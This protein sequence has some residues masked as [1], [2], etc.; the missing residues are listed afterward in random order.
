MRRQSKL[1]CRW[2]TEMRKTGVF[3]AGERVGVA[4]SGG[5]DSILLLDF[6]GQFASKV[7]LRV[8]VVHFNHLLRGEESNQDESF[9]SALAAR[10]KLEFIRAEGDVGRVARQTRR[11]LEATARELRYR[12]FF[13]L[14]RQGRLDRIAT[15][16]TAN[17]QAETV[18]LRLMRGAGARGLGGIHPVLDGVIVR[19]FLGITRQEVEAEIRS[20]RLEFRTDT[21]NLD[22]RFVRNRIRQKLLP[23]LET[24]FNAAIVPHLKQLADHMRSDEDLLEQQAREQARPWRIR[25][26]QEEKIPLRALRELPRALQVR[27]L[28]QMAASALSGQASLSSVQFE[29]ILHFVVT[30]VSGK[31]LLLA[32]GLEVRRDFD[33]LALRH[34]P[35]EGCAAPYCYAVPLPGEVAVPALGLKFRFEVAENPKTKG[36]DK[37]YNNNEG[38]IRLDLGKFQGSL[39][40]RN[41]REGDRFQ[42]VGHRKSCKLKELFRER[43]IPVAHRKL[44]PVIEGG[45]EIVW[46]RSFPSSLAAV[47]TST[48]SQFLTIIE[49]PLQLPGSG[50]PL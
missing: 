29:S 1:Y 4:V 21:S 24:E 38:L 17:D 7:G 50:I 30:A 3:R 44:W 2:D 26:G 19:P 8:S 32:G 18:L 6:M 9:V 36:K 20:R 23:L 27:I 46:V 5:P 40:L 47:A 45:K 49:E 14:I 35:P 22:P 16:H 33:W 31:R 41:W 48:T 10:R 25:D 13:S 42:P 34:V 28:R 43:K 12:F 11:N 15:A 39:I 37:A